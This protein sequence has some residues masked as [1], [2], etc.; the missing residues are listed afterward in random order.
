MRKCAYCGKEYP[1]DATDCV[2]DGQRL[3]GLPPVPP[4][5]IQRPEG[6]IRTAAVVMR[7]LFGLWV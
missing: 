7:I 3:S 4:P 2:I 6:L 5:Q 1:D